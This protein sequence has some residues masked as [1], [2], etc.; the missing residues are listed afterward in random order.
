M[1]IRTK[2]DLTYRKARAIG[3]QKMLSTTKIAGLRSRPFLFKPKLA[4]KSLKTS[5]ISGSGIG[6]LIEGKLK[7]T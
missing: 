7:Y 3:Q 2:G 5:G 1:K 4:K 6:K